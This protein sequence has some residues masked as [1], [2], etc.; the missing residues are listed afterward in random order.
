MLTCDRSVNAPKLSMINRSMSGETIKS[1]N[2][3]AGD[4]ALFSRM[5]P[6]IPWASISMH[7]M[8]VAIVQSELGSVKLKSA[9]RD[10]LD[11][12]NDL[13]AMRLELSRSSSRDVSR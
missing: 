7:L 4:A 3:N 13:I 8:P 12:S 6:P 10:G 1:G 2:F 11:V 9:R 5:T